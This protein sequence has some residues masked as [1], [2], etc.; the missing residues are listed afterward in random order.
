MNSALNDRYLFALELTRRASVIALDYFAEYELL[1]VDMKANPQDVVSRA[2]REIEGFIRVQIAQSFPFDE[3]VGEEGSKDFGNADFT[4]V[5]DPIDG[6]MPFI[7]G[8]PHWCIAIALVQRGDIVLAVTHAP[9]IDQFYDAM[10]GAGA[11]LNGVPI[12]VNQS[13]GVVGRMTGIGASH[14]VNATEVATTIRRLLR[15]GGIFYRNGSGALMLAEVAS[16]KL[17]GYYEG[18]MNA[19]DCLGGILL[20]QEAGGKVAPV[21]IGQML[22]HGG[23]V[24]AA[25]PQAFDQ[26]NMLVRK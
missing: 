12:K 23:S 9:V 24:L 13:Q 14:R 5:I 1:A 11:R 18:H 20:V 25:A 10:L 21:L 15:A 19:W 8:L 17:A 2:D 22:R 6:T 16:G 3:I 7:S 26:I 4:W